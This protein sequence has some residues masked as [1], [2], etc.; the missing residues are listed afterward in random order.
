[1]HF[2]TKY[3]FK[4]DT[5]KGII[6]KINYNFDQILSFAIG[7][8]GHPGPRGA[9]GIY[10]PAGKRGTTG[11]PGFRASQWYKQ[12]TEP[13]YAFSNDV[14]IDN[15]VSDGNIKIYDGSV[16]DD[17]GYAFLNSIYFESY[18]N[19]EGPGGATDKYVIGFKNPGITGSSATS[20]LINDMD[21]IPSQSNPNNSKVLVST[22]DQIDRPVM[23][24]SKNGAI[25]NDVPSF[26]WNSTGNNAGLKFDSGG[27]FF[28]TTNDDFLIDSD[29]ARTLITSSSCTFRN[30]L[31]DLRIYGDGDFGF[32]S[33]IT[34]G[35]GGILDVITSNLRVN[36]SSF[37]HTGGVTITSPLTSTYILSS[38]PSSPSYQNGISVR[39]NTNAIKTFEF[40]D[41]TG[42]PVLY[43]RPAGS[44]V[45]SANKMA[46]TVFGT[47]GGFGAGGTAGPFSYHVRKVKEVRRP[48][49]RLSAK[50]YRTTTSKILNDVFDISANTV[51]ENDMIIATP[52]VYTSSSINGIA[53]FKVGAVDLNLNYS[54]ELDIFGSGF[55]NS[56][57]GN[58]RFNAVVNGAVQ[59]NDGSMIFVGNFKYYN[60]VPVGINPTANLG[61][62]KVNQTGEM[63]LEFR[64]YLSQLNVRYVNSVNGILYDGNNDRIFVYGN[65]AWRSV[66]TLPGLNR[67]GI[68]CLDSLF[69]TED[70]NFSANQRS[71]FSADSTVYNALYDPIIDPNYIYAVGTFTTYDEMPSTTRIR[72]KI[73]KIHAR[74]GNI[75]KCVATFPS[76]VPTAN[77]PGF[78][79]TNT[80]YCLCYGPS[81]NLMVGGTFTA[82]RNT[83]GTTNFSV[84]HMIEI[85]EGTG[86]KITTIGFASVQYSN[87]PNQFAFMAVEYNTETASYW[88]GGNFIDI[89]GGLYRRIVTF[90]D[91]TGSGEHQLMPYSNTNF[92][93]A[94]GF[95]DTVFDFYFRTGQ[96][97]VGG[98]FNTYKGITCPGFIRLDTLGNIDPTASIYHD[99]IGPEI[100]QP[101]YKYSVGLVKKIYGFYT[102]S[103]SSYFVYVGGFL[104]SDFSDPSSEGA[105]YLKVPSSLT[106]DYVP[107]YA[108]N[109][110]T[111]YR[112][113]LN[114]RNNNPKSHYLKGLVFDTGL[115]TAVTPSY[116]DFSTGEVL[117]SGGTITNTS[118][119]A[120][121]CQ[122]V[123]LMWV[124]KT[125]TANVGSPRLFYKSCDGFGGYVDFGANGL[126]TTSTSPTTSTGQ[127]VTVTWQFGRDQTG[128]CSIFKNGTSLTNQVLNRTVAGSG[129]LGYL[130]GDNIYATVSSGGYSGGFVGASA[131]LRIIR[132]SLSTGQ[133]TTVFSQTLDGSNV[134]PNNFLNPILVAAGFSYLIDC[135]TLSENTGFGCCFVGDTKINMSDGGIKNIEDVLI[136]ESILTYNVE[137]SVYEPGVVSSIEA[138]IK[139]DIIEFILS[140]GTVINATTEHPFWVIDKGWSSYSPAR[141]MLD[142]QMEVSKIENGDLLLDNEGN[143]VILLNMNE[144]KS[145]LQKVYNIIM[146]E[147]NHTYFANGILV[148]NKLGSG[149]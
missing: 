11:N 72:N 15:S 2:N 148:H 46:Q 40:N 71:G 105:V 49:T 110:T 99:I 96:V 119:G 45:A 118:T 144:G 126:P 75:G 115:P 56:L 127:S 100:V 116:I 63:D 61:I 98:R 135:S 147:G 95:N 122:Y 109:T 38:N 78:V 43:G 18:S 34:I 58:D 82:Y 87:I 26:Y 138:P 55:S 4:G 14:W 6:G 133:A 129:T 86:L 9:T 114:D 33:N 146:S 83:T 57:T 70:F 92:R 5:E 50:K 136:G 25:S 137:T 10:G 66:I 143:E 139:D 59:T 67:Y 117:S 7:P 107:V 74:G 125:S 42:N 112:V 30:N 41:Y 64:G 90:Y 29:L 65:F 81:G 123:D 52:S 140:N 88:G 85:D 134:S 124:S 120:T 47:S 39:T 77:G 145:E 84:K 80:P 3:I 17:S 36:V 22:L 37:N 60:G 31:G 101:S 48:T 27:S 53:S 68:V 108:D 19:I 1:M 89:N 121:G 102:L 73:I 62:C 93:D 28:I 91:Y 130:V 94:N 69:G 44:S 12:P 54:P 141:T 23:A 132:T 35:V 32:S 16:W 113:F 142:H 13:T 111:N 106:P 20:L 131:E 97:Y 76:L 21:L 128:S 104:N 24:F 79:G 103:L 51:W 149:V 8:D